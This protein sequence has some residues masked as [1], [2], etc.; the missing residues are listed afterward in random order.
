MTQL[1]PIEPLS[2]ILNHILMPLMINNNY[3]FSIHPNLGTSALGDARITKTILDFK[4]LT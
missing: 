3:P 1:G 2:L 4:K